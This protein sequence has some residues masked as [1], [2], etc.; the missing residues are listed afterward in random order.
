MAART[1]AAKKGLPALTAKIR[2]PSGEIFD[3]YDARYTVQEDR[4]GASGGGGS[5]GGSSFG[6][7]WW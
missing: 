5:W 6:P 4:S 7:V 2:L 3:H 1:D